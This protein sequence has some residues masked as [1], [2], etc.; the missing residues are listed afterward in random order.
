MSSSSAESQWMDGR[1][2]IKRCECGLQAPVWT[3]TTDKNRG[4]RF[5]GCGR[6]LSAQK[7]NFFEWVEDEECVT[8]LRRIDTLLQKITSVE[9]N[10]RVKELEM[11][12]EIKS[13]V[14]GIGLLKLQ[15]MEEE[16]KM[17]K[18]GNKTFSWNVVWFG[19]LVIILLGSRIY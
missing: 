14:R 17:S 2:R 16:L 10:F 13:C 7:C 19:L 6:F 4:K 15:N 1:R 8:C 11:Q 3:A 5:H 18:K 9:D 12:A